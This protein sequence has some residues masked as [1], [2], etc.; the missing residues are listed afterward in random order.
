M[1]RAT[2]G[3]VGQ[4]ARR[5]GMDPRSLFEKMRKHGLRKSAFHPAGEEPD[6][7]DA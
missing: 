1:L 2:G 5:A 6:D 3:R 4:A 7:S